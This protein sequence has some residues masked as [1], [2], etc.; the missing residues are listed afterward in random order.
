MSIAIYWDVDGTLLL[1][2]PGR[3]DLFLSTVESLG[4]PPSKPAG[5]REGLTDRRVG[6]LYLEAAGLAPDLIDSFLAELDSQ[7]AAFYVQHPRE[8][9]PGVHVAIA[10]V[11]A[12]GWRQ[13]LM[14]GNTP[15]RIRTKLFTAGIDPT[16]FDMTTS[17]SGGFVSDR[18]E[19]GRQ[20]RE[21]SGDDTLV[22]IGD[23]PH[24][25]RAARAAGA[26][27][28]GVTREA[29]TRDELEPHALAVVETLADP[30]FLAA[31][32]RIAARV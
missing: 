9:M 10:E 22:V 8:P 16:V 15:S 28:I 26:L 12:R 14:S 24:D 30:A 1:A 32:D 18:D 21:R 25:L 7:S 20:A 19:L 31:L 27:F 3:A 4:G 17:V 23:T 2:P 6:E 5:R 11:A 29:A 13:A